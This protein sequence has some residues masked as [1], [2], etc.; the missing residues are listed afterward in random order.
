MTDR[1][2]NHTSSKSSSHPSPNRQKLDG[3]NGQIRISQD[4]SCNDNWV[5]HTDQECGQMMRIFN[6]IGIDVLHCRQL[7]Y[8]EQGHTL[9]QRVDDVIRGWEQKTRVCKPQTHNVHEQTAWTNNEGQDSPVSNGCDANYKYMTLCKRSDNDDST[10]T[11]NGNNTVSGESHVLSL[12]SCWV[13][14]TEGHLS[15]YCSQT[16]GIDRQEPDSHTLYPHVMHVPLHAIPQLCNRQTLPQT[17]KSCESESDRG[18]GK[19]TKSS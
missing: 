5:P 18:I 3:S 9:E 16:N 6:Q 14:G 4:P 2:T 11:P 15:Q 12:Y 8:E 10:L 7:Q 17:E 1:E 13:Y 19:K